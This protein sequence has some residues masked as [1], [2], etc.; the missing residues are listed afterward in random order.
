MSM[1]MGEDVLAAAEACHGF[2]EASAGADW[3][4]PVP[5]LDFTVASV[6]AHAANGADEIVLLDFSNGMQELGHTRSGSDGSF[7]FS[8]PYS[9]RPRILQVIHQGTPYYK[10]ALPASSSI[11]VE[12]YDVSKKLK[13]IVV[14]ADM[15]V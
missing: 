12:V 13:D 4:A 3:S 1:M 5:D 2:L 14:K 7:S 15:G 6:V 10:T 8:V 9:K 11:G